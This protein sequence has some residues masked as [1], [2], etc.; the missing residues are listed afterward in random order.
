MQVRVSWVKSVSTDVVVQKLNWL[1]NGEVVRSVNL[2]PNV[3]ER[4][5]GQDGVAFT[6][7][8]VV[9]V[10][11]V[12]NDGKSDSTPVVGEV[13]VPLVPPEPVTNLVIEL[14]LSEE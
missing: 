4:L 12:V 7:G 1:V 5:S 11:I 9:G 6:E 14:V 3:T 13:N 8:D 2:L 10:S